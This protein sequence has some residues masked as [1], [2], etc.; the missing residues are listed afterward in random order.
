MSYV[1]EGRSARERVLDAVFA[2]VVK[3][4]IGEASLRKVADESGVNIGSVRH[5]FGSHSGLLR[6]AAEEVG[7]RMELRL[8]AASAEASLDTLEGRRRYVEAVALAL[9]PR[10]GAPIDDHIVLVEFV[11][12][13]RVLPELRDAAA[14]MGR[15]MRSVVAEALSSAGVDDVDF[16]TERLVALIDGL[17]FELVYPHG[18][19]DIQRTRDI[20]RG[21]IRMVVT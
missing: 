17:T 2:M 21:H 1:E 18:I 20:L 16:E 12:A 11:S 4:G 6:A 15:D 9:L 14:Q 8:K 13:A 10:V 19:E 5:F 7:S 3:G